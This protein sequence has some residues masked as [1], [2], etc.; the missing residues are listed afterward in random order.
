M[1]DIIKNLVDLFVNKTIKY[2]GDFVLSIIAYGSCVRGDYKATSDIDLLIIV[3]DD[4]FSS[5]SERISAFSRIHG[6]IWKSSGYKDAIKKDMPHNIMEIVY[7]ESE[8]RSHPPLLLDITEDGIILYDKDDL[9]RKELALMKKKMRRLGSRRVWLD[10][11]RWYWI[12]KPD[13]KMGE[14]IKI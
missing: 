2:C 5:Y 7:T 13:I 9:A 12:L 1:H 11:K 4:Q 14:I 3:K 8:F 10:R 6:E